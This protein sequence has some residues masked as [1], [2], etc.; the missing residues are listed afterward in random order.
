MLEIKNSEEMKNVLDVLIGRWH[1]WELSE[2]KAC[3]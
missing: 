2:L 3:Q 1:N